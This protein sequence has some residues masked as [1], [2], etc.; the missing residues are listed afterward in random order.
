ML[1]T[2]VV[3]ELL[4]VNMERMEAGVERWNNTCIRTKP[5]FNKFLGEIASNLAR[6]IKVNTK[7]LSAVSK[8]W[9]K[10]KSKEGEH[11]APVKI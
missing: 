9:F 11:P 6:L 10:K 3:T 2:G 7:Y 8:A 4:A 5:L 1:L